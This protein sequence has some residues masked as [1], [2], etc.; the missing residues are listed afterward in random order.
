MHPVDALDLGLAD[1]ARWTRITHDAPASR[2]RLIRFQR[3]ASASGTPPVFCRFALG[4]QAGGW[5]AEATR[6]CHGVG[7]PES[8]ATPELKAGAVRFESCP[9][10]VHSASIER[11]G[12]NNH[13]S[14]RLSD[15]RLFYIPSSLD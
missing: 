14:A 5:P 2:A 13:L 9:R 8:P 3:I 10:R 7:L 1:G 4:V 11:P 12:P 15:Q 6:S